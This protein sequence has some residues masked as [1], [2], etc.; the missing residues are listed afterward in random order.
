VSAHGLAGNPGIC[1]FTNDIYQVI[2]VKGHAHRCENTA[3]DFTDFVVEVQM[4]IVNGD[5]GGT[6]FR[7]DDQT[8]NYYFFWISSTGTYGLE[9]WKNDTLLS[10][11]SSGSSAAIH[12]GLN[13]PNTV[14]VVAKGS[15]FKLYVN[16]QLIDT[17][18]DKVNSY[19]HGRITLDAS[20]TS[21]DTEVHFSNIK[22]WT[23]GS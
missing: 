20:S 6:E 8:G 14:A 10:T 2:T 15:T 21:S 16:N 11:L 17:V 12:S 18:T 9:I 1:T 19:G 7:L 23:P 4:T 3:Y 22:V 5:Q 13:Q